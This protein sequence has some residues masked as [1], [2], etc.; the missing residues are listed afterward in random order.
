MSQSNEVEKQIERIVD[1]PKR[2]AV[3]WV[4]SNVYVVDQLQ[5]PTIKVCNIDEEKCATLL[6]ANNADEVTS[7]VLDPSQG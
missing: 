1:K 7:I 2:L 6:S 3:D 5:F 4:T